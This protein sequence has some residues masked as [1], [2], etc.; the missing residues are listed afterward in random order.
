MPVQSNPEKKKPV[1]ILMELSDDE[2]ARML[3]ESRQE[4]LWQQEARRRESLA[5]GLAE[6]K[7]KKAI[8]IAEKLLRKNMP[9]SDIAEAVGLTLAEVEHLASKLAQ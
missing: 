3:E 8:E 4:A 6:G 7:Q 9:E 2:R 5:E 1:G